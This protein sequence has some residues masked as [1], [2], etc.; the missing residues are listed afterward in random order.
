MKSIKIYMENCN[1]EEISK[2]ITIRKKS[3]K[4]SRIRI[5]SESRN[6]GRKSLENSENS[7]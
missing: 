1:G 4:N 5:N 7:D 3:E 6:A 2:S